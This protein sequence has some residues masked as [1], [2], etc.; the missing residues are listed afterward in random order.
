MRY[1]GPP[2]RSHLC[3][4]C[5]RARAERC[6]SSVRTSV[7]VGYFFWVDIAR[8]YF[9]LFHSLSSAGERGARGASKTAKHSAADALKQQPRHPCVFAI[10]GRFKRKK[11]RQKS[12][13]F[14]W[15]K[16]Q[17]VARQLCAMGDG[18]SNF[19]RSRTGPASLHQECTTGE[20]RGTAQILG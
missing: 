6:R 10:S 16:P 1:D 3:G 4:E 18:A 7:G 5:A 13:K 20:D 15:N 17:P 12:N 9:L 11:D 19:R 14:S 8:T 2:W